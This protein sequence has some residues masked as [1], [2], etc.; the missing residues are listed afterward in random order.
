MHF[1][2]YSIVGV[3][4]NTGE[5]GGAAASC[6]LAVGGSV[7]HLKGNAVI[8]VQH[9]ASPSLA[10]DIFTR[11]SRGLTCAHALATAL[12]ADDQANNRQVLVATVGS[13]IAAHTGTECERKSKHV[14]GRNCAA[15][16]NALLDSAIIDRMVSSF[17]TTI[18]QSLASRL[19]EAMEQGELMGGDKRGKQSSVLKVAA[20][21]NPGKW[22]MY[23]DLR[24]D[25]HP[26]PI[27]ELRR[28]L[29][30]FN[31]RKKKWS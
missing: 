26:E 11:L 22:Y 16:G 12:A 18:G 2:T 29:T 10:E 14:V 30:K 28:L 20:P 3:D 23:P 13:E 5:V 17:E 1:N 6:V 9:H 25:D 15:A 7:I 4:P 27:S 8:N 21:C 31:E 19:M 24:V